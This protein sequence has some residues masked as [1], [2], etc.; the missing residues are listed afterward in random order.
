MLFQD[1]VHHAMTYYKQSWRACGGPQTHFSLAE[2]AQRNVPKSASAAA[3]L[4]VLR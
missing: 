4:L 1:K 2:H 3:A